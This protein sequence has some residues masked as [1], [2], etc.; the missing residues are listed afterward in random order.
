MNKLN[1]NIKKYENIFEETFDNFVINESIN[2]TIYNTQKFLKTHLENK[3]KDETIM[4][5]K[6][7]KLISVVPCCKFDNKYFSHKGCTFGG[8]IIS[9]SVN[10]ITDLDEIIKIIFNHYDNKI[11]LRMADYIYNNEN[12]DCLYYLL[13]TKTIQKNE[14]S[15]FVATDNKWYLN[16]DNK[17]NQKY[18]EKFEKDINNIIYIATCK[19]D[20]FLFY[21]ILQQ[22]LNKNHN[23]EPTHNLNEF[24]N[25]SEIMKNEHKLYLAKNGDEI[26]G[27]VYVV[28]TN[29]NCWYTFYIT[30]NINTKND[31]CSVIAIMKKICIDAYN[32]GVKFIDYGTSTENNGELLNLGLSSYKE[33]SFGGK[34]HLRY[35]FL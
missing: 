24:L 10:N 26:L 32:D 31:N 30:R 33:K 15:W 12:I 21:N 7:D 27:G 13:N 4:I 3:F 18:L 35:L 25:F 22:N 19:E 8:I 6:G 34:P 29:K 28:L 2:G 5:Y 23:T 9:K 20:Y 1:F 16:L 17:R 11:Q 14:L